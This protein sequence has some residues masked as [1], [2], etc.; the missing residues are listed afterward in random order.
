[1]NQKDI[2]RKYVQIRKEKHS[3]IC[4]F[5]KYDDRFRTAEYEIF[6]YKLVLMSWSPVMEKENNEN[7][8]ANKQKNDWQNHM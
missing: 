2:S 6:R 3:Q 8:M 1:M 5:R 7:E 4:D